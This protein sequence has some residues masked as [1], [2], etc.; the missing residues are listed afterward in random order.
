MDLILLDE[1]GAVLAAS[2]TA[3]ALI[4]LPRDAVF[5]GLALPA[6]LGQSHPLL[7]LVAAAVTSN[8]E[9]REMTI[10]ADN[11]G[12]IEQP[13]LVMSIF[14]LK[15][16]RKTT[17]FLLTLREKD[18]RQRPAERSSETSS[19]PEQEAWISDAAHHLRSPLH[20]MNMRLEL[21]SREVADT[22][23]HRHV[24]KLRSQIQRLD[25]AVEELLRA[26]GRMN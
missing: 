15:D 11:S 18:Q 17:G 12:Q 2:V 24:E 7:P 1:S 25:Q 5:E 19:P 9:T 3:R 16:G 21:L 13:S 23:A 10:S 6:L 14:R 4:G 20:G 22:P 26:C 8:V